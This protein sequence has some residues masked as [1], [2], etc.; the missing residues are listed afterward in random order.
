MDWVSNKLYW[1]D[2]SLAKIAVLDLDSL[3]QAD[4]LQLEPN[5]PPKAI[6]IDPTSK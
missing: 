6:A 1:A 2:S 4:V 5:S 3:L